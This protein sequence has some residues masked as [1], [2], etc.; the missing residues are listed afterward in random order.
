MRN[1]DGTEPEYFDA[2]IEFEH[3]GYAGTQEEVSAKAKRNIALLLKEYGR[4]PQ[5][6]YKLY[7]LGKSYY[8]KQDYERAYEFF[9]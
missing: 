6:V 8:M 3:S 5:D 2:P 7:Q 4:K 1:F 9:D